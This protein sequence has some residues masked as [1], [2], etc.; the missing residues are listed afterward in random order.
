MEQS[1]RV[2]PCAKRLR[3]GI[4]F[5]RNEFSGAFG[6]LGT[7]FPLIVGM[8]LVAGLDAAS[9]LIM[10]GGMQI[11]TGLLY[12]IPMPAQPLKAVAV[13]VI[14]QRL[15]GNILYGG[16]F[17]IGL[18]M[19]VLTVTGLI[20]WLAKAVPKSVV[21]GVQCGLGLQ[22]AML[23]L[24]DYVPA[25]GGVGY[26][27]AAAAFGLILVLLGNRRYPPA[28]FVIALGILYAVI[29]RIDTGV[30]GQSLG[31]SLPSLHV[32]TPQD[33]L[34]GFLVL[35][36]PQI[37][38]SLGNSILA[39]R[40]MVEDLFPTRAVSVRQIGRTYTL[41]NLINPFFGGV[42]T[43]HGSGGIVGQYAFGARTGGSVIIYGA[44]YLCLGLFL[45]GGFTEAI[46]LFPKPILGMI[47]LF[48]GLAVLQLVQDM[49][50]SK[51]DFTVVLLVGLVAVSLP[52]GYV[53][54]MVGGTL[55]AALARKQ[56][57]ALANW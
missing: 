34:T 16:G 42:P 45:S 53:I 21:R 4:R 41:M 1:M 46:L 33:I 47:L 56:L 52:Y 54:G 26:G 6:D 23:A 31:L 22:L 39:T 30:L 32:P 13:L 28:P 15:N 50:Q 57:V 43:C 51:A 11:L 38:L 9:V 37:P 44:L 24:K 25:E 14:T 17:A 49:A 36:L 55:M 18:T 48:E 12:G 5:D 7:D 40:Q 8:I 35:A 3:T 19:L 10:F 27:L 2:P 20:D 29:A